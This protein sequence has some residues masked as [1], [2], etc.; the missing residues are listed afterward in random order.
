MAPCKY[1]GCVWS[2]ALETR[3]GHWVDESPTLWSQPCCRL[4]APERP[5]QSRL[6]P[7]PPY[8][9]YLWHG[10][11]TDDYQGLLQ[12][13]NHQYF[14]YSFAADNVKCLI[15]ITPTWNMFLVCGHHCLYPQIPKDHLLWLR[16]HLC[17]EWRKNLW[18]MNQGFVL[19]LL[20]FW[21]ITCH[22]S[23]CSLTEIAP[24]QES[25]AHP[26]QT[27][28]VQKVIT[29]VFAPVCGADGGPGHE[30]YF[31]LHEPVPSRCLPWFC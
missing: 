8:S 23:L 26:C 30:F 17:T 18:S 25:G 5:W 11:R 10:R 20:L 27:L 13:Y 3:S 31:L 6:L 19:F 4:G 9:P 21:I 14:R 16:T 28:G 1:L 29:F 12:F 24:D 15:Q 2:C 22:K 7:A